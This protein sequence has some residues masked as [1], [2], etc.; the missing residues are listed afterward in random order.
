MKTENEGIKTISNNDLKYKRER[1]GFLLN[2]RRIM[3]IRALYPDK[4][5][6][7]SQISEITNIQRPDIGFHVTE[8]VMYKI[9]SGDFRII[10]Q[11][12]KTEKGLAGQFYKLTEFGKNYWEM[13]LNNQFI[14]VFE[15]ILEDV[16]FNKFQERL[17][18]NREEAKK[19]QTETCNNETTNKLRRY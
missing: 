8:M 10:K 1:M 9:L 17:E 11:P 13:I 7:L 19:L 15:K 14:E 6:H 2:P 18:Q 4:E 3:I 12:T 5:M 16:A